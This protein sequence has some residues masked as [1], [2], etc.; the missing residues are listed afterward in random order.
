MEQGD[1]AKSRCQGSQI[2]SKRIG[3]E[4]LILV[5]RSQEDVKMLQSDCTTYLPSV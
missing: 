3:A 1:A 4:A 2:G 5:G